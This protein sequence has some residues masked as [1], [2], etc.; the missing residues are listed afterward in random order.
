MS[1]T[2]ESAATEP[3]ADAATTW[4]AGWRLDAAVVVLSVL[5]VAGVAWDFRTHAAGITFAEESFFTPSHVFFYS[6]F[7]LI[8]ATLG[9]A[10]Y[11]NRRQGAPWNRAVPEGYAVGVLG[12]GLFFVG[13]AG[14]YLWHSAFGFEIGVDALTSPTHIL[15]ATGAALFF[16][17]PL[18]ATWRRSDDGPLA[19]A[20]VSAG[21]LLT[22]PTMFTAYVNP[23][24]QPVAAEAAGGYVKAGGVAG[25]IVFTVIL[26]GG[27]LALVDRFD[28]PFGA[29]TLVF[30]IVGVVNA[31]VRPQLVLV[32]AVLF[33]AYF[34]TI[35]FAWGIA[36]PVHVWTGSVVLAGAAGL[37]V[38]YVSV[39][40][41]R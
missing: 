16:S 33:A 23:L 5:M 9:A 38:S 40:D 41:G 27:M 7:L 13:G 29:F 6:A 28:L 8:A 11:R 36:W 34:L 17:S 35:A 30:A 12:V 19:P 21:L 2:T 22:V 3:S 18:R 14:D 26:S 4:L 15:L 31:A 37:L 10:T 24:V 32:P 1:G 39:P 20:L 25:V